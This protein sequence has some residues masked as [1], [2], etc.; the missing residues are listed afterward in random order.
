[1]GK[2][3]QTKKG[4]SGLNENAAVELEINQETPSTIDSTEDQIRSH[5]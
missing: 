2:K 5:P 4:Q 3:K 1:M